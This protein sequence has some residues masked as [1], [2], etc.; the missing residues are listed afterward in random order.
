M[1]PKISVITVTF[2]AEKYIENCI[3][4]VL[5][6]SYNNL[7]YIIIDGNSSDNTMRIVNKFKVD[8]SY[9]LS[10]K[11]NGIYDAMNKG[12]LHST[13][14]Y[15]YFL[16]ADDRF[17]NNDVIANFVSYTEKVDSDIYYGKVRYVDSEL[18][19][20]FVRKQF[21]PV[22]T[23]KLFRYVGINHQSIFSK[24]HILTSGFN[25]DYNIASD[26]DWVI[27]SYRLGYKFQC[28][29][30]IVAKYNF[31][32]V[33]SLNTKE[34]LPEINKI[35]AVYFGKFAGTLIS[36]VIK[37]NLIKLKILNLIA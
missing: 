14:D 26:L 28:I 30:L 24:K 36:F 1:Y 10:E 4:S 6:Q 16:G 25:L 35:Y 11:D 23:L 13:G 34:L 15:I 5:N 18:N 27:K 31:G 17:E 8:I 33:S 9:I 20:M 21:Q 12:I 3:Y 37:F 22:T 2:N 7:E 19:E 29:D 32:G